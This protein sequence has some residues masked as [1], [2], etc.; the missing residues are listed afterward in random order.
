VRNAQVST[1]LESKQ[2]K[3][4]HE[5]TP[6]K[7]IITTTNKKKTRKHEPNKNKSDMIEKSQK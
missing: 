5:K 6:S 7:Q 4:A 3:S 2:R 1:R